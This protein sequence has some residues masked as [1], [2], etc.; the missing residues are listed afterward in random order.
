MLLVTEQETEAQEE[1]GWGCASPHPPGP[2]ASRA[3][4]SSPWWTLLSGFA[5]FSLRVTSLFPAPFPLPRLSALALWPPHSPHQSPLSREAC[6]GGV[7][8]I[9]LQGV[10]GG[11]GGHP[12]PDQHGCR[13][14]GPQE[15]H[16]H[17]WGNSRPRSPWS[18]ERPPVSISPRSAVCAGGGL[19]QH[20]GAS[21]RLLPLS[22]G[23]GQLGLGRSWRALR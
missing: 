22:W 20:S 15:L 10:W 16:L 5:R 18:G 4:S 12:V 1:Q 7:E 11:G 13:P 23:A 14:A 8:V 9:L 3:G 17:R 19:A 2:A 21:G 6:P